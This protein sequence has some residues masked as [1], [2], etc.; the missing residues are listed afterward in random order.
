MAAFRFR[1]AVALD[2]RLKQETDALV[3]RARVQA[4]FLEAKRAVDAEV[5]RRDTARTDLVALERS[6]A[7][8]DTLLWH[9][10]WIVRLTANAD[11]LQRDLYERAKDVRTADEAWHEA[12]RRRLALERMK[13]RAWQR[14]QK[15]ELREEMKQMDE[16]ARIRYV[17]PDAWRPREG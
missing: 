12:R 11:G 7:E 2:L 9:R 14:Y 3:E 6:G 5:A 15:A 17:M 16:L 10:N 4:L 13:D 8:L 1:A